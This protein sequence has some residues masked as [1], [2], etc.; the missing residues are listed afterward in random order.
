MKKYITLL[1][2]LF[3]LPSSALAITNYNQGW[4]FS[5]GGTSQLQSS[6]S[7]TFNYVTAT[8]TTAS[9]TFANGINLTKGCFSVAGVCFSGVTAGVDTYIPISLS[10][11]F[12]YTPNLSYCRTCVGNTG[13]F[14]AAGGNINLN[15]LGVQIGDTGN[16]GNKTKLTID[17][18]GKD[19]YLQTD[20]F[21]V[22]GRVSP[23]RSTKFGIG[24][25]TPAFELSVEGTSSLGNYALAGSFEATTTATSTF[26]GGL[27]TNLLNITSTTASSTFA[28]GV[29][30][31]KGCFA[32]NNV[33]VGGSPSQWTTAG[34]SIYYT[35]GGVGIGTTSPFSAL[36]VSTSTT[37]TSGN[38]KLFT[39]A[40]STGAELFTVL[41]SGN[42]GIGTKSPA[43]PFDVEA[44]T[45]SFIVDSTGNLTINRG[46]SAGN[47]GVIVT[48]TGGGLP[49]IQVGQDGSNGVQEFWSGGAGYIG[50]VS[51]NAPLH[52]LGSYETF[53]PAGTEMMGVTSSG[54]RIGTTSPWG[55]VS[56]NPPAHGTGP[57]FVVG[58]S[59][60]TNFVITNAGNIG[61]NTANP[62]SLVDIEA[63]T[64]NLL[65]D[66]TGAVTISRGSSAGN[67]GVF[68]YGSGGGVPLV[69]VGQDGS[70]AFQQYWSGGVAYMGTV[71]NNAPVQFQGSYESFAPAGV[72]AMRVTGSK[73]GIGT[74]SP[75]ATLSIQ[76][77]ASTGDAFAIAT[78]SGKAI[79][80]CDNDGHCWTS[81][82]PPAISVCGTGTGTVV[83]DDQS[84]T[85]TTATAA[86]AC[87]ATFSKAYRNTP[88]CTVT[89]DSL[90]GFADVSAISTTAVTFG[91]SSALTGGHLYYSCKYHQ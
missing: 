56:I 8:S 31:T 73:V 37:G 75:Y 36:A 74:T 87:T 72:E 83:G 84:G 61:I 13:Q 43:G 22:L 34:N 16:L 32:I 9:S 90:V 52:I 50:T 33:C 45:G 77:G 80:G 3:L 1:L 42:I 53:D 40:S 54:V 11:G 57:N 46:S 23:F 5:S 71:S 7:P 89:D 70:N 41:G 64:G 6:T 12:E 44:A 82:P 15:A 20:N 58:S 47:G 67:G 51:N 29:N 4:I 2:G 49:L 10:G 55:Y 27:K 30:L 21:E 91:I 59:T 38:T 79:A 24:T 26:A 19:A 81:G 14:Y 63:A 88:T 39:V 60:A 62:S 25:T 68:V 69:Q 17:D 18:T 85:I 28:N 76:T 66:S 65:V 86:T 48:G 35:T 78:S